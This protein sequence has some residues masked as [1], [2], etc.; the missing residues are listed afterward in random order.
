MLVA[1]ATRRILLPRRWL[2]EDDQRTPLLGPRVDPAHTKALILHLLV[3]FLQRHLSR[4]LRPEPGA[5]A[6]AARFDPQ[7]LAGYPPGA[8]TF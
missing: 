5:P 3:R 8:L 1:S 7:L 4:R 2:V 6:E